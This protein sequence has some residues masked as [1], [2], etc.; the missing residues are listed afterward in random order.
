M[1]V[2]ALSVRGIDILLG[3]VWEWETLVVVIEVEALNHF[4][5]I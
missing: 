2:L 1:R 5:R 3:L 4:D